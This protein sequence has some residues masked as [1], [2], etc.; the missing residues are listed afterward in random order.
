MDLTRETRAAPGILN[1][2]TRWDDLARELLAKDGD[3]RELFDLTAGD[4]DYPLLLDKIFEADSVH[5]W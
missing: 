1:I 5:V 3:G 2:V 4:P